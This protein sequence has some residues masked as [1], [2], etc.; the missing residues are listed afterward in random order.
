MTVL[1]ISRYTCIGWTV[2]VGLQAITTQHREQDL[3]AV[4]VRP[5]RGHAERRLWDRLC[6]KHHYLP[7]HGL[8]GRP[9]GRSRR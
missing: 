5:T 2:A 7:F 4:R 9:S 6:A 1:N 3:C 8:F